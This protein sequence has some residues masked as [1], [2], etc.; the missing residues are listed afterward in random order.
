MG[1]RGKVYPSRFHRKFQGAFYFMMFECFNGFWN[2]VDDNPEK[3][4]PYL[5]AVY[6][7]ILSRANRIGWK[8]KFAII[9]IDLQESTGIASRTTLLK[10][11][12]KLEE[13]GFI[14]TISHSTNQYKNRI[15]SLSF[16]EKHLNSTRKANEN[17]VEITRT[18]IKTN[19]TIKT[20][21][22][23]KENKVYKS[24]DEIRAMTFFQKSEKV[25]EAF[26]DFLINRITNKHYPTTLAIK[27][28]INK[29]KEIYKTEQ[30]AL[31]GIARS[32]EGNYKGLFE[33]NKN[34]TKQ[35]PEQKVVTRAS[36]GIKMQ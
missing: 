9:L 1:L 18:H 5:A 28:L 31:D 2:W 33:A 24:V 17:Q 8:D 34:T 16:N 32:I 21:K 25:N 3:I 29:M 6:F 13:N 15:I 19:K 11:L 26:K 12:L 7:A 22:D 10:C 36:M 20:N 27:S 4:D 30:Q 23:N 14:K 35:Q